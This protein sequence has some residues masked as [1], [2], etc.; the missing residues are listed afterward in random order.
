[1][2]HANTYEKER[3][4]VAARPCLATRLDQAGPGW[5]PGR[6]GWQMCDAHICD[7]ISF[8]TP[9]RPKPSPARSS[10][11]TTCLFP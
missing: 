4:L 2:K 8:A 1:M 11:P 6:A 7:E 3:Y 9:L 5:S 10:S